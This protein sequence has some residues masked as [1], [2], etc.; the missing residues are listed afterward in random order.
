MEFNELIL[1][2]GVSVTAVALLLAWVLYLKFFV[3]VPPNQALVIFGK[4]RVLFGEHDAGKHGG[5]RTGPRIV[6]GGGAFVPPWGK[7]HG[8]LPLHTFDVDVQVRTTTPVGPALSRGWDVSIGVQARIPPDAESLRSAAEN[9]LGKSEDELRG[10][11]RRAVEGYVPTVLAKIPEGEVEHDWD[12]IGAE[13]QSY[14]AADLV[15]LGLVIRS[16]TVKQIAPGGLG[17][18]TILLPPQTILSLPS[19]ES[20][21]SGGSSRYRGLEARV[22]AVDRSFEILGLEATGVTAPPAPGN[23]RPGGSIEG[24]RE[25]AGSPQ[26]RAGALPVYGSTAAPTP[27]RARASRGSAPSEAGPGV[28]KHLLTTDK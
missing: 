13:V 4:G 15:A 27:S 16:L 26:R 20:G 14:A 24:G 17:D 28:G 19:G 11:V 1:L 8:F 2:I 22:D 21:G 10:I 9:L 12:K 3:I 23:G 7:G 6:V 18:A 5:R 25:P